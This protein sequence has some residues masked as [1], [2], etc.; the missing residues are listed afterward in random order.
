MAWDA[1]TVSVSVSV[2]RNI[3]AS[4]AS[5][6]RRDMTHH[7]SQDGQKAEAAGENAA[8]WLTFVRAPPIIL[9]LASISWSW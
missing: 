9:L 3:E 2:Q 7:P 1:S 8:P 4:L 6:Q 5:Q